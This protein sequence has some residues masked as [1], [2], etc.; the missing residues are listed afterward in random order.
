VV[1]DGTD[2]DPA[3]TAASTAPSRVLVAYQRFA[4]E[5]LYGGVDRVFFRFFAEPPIR[6]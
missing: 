3:G 1:P 4:T 5:P 2:R 6:R